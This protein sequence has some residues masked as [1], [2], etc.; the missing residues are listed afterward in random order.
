[1]N[2]SSLYNLQDEILGALSDFARKEEFPFVLTGGTALVRFLLKRTYRV[3]YDLDFFYQGLSL[4]EWSKRELEVF[5]LGRFPL[6]DFRSLSSSTLNMWRAVI[7]NGSLM[8]A[9]DFVE[10]PFSG[11]FETVPLEDF[12][13][14]KMETAQEGVY[15][16][17]VFAITSYTREEKVIERIKDVVDLIELDKLIFLQDFILQTYSRIMKQNFGPLNRRKFLT[18]FSGLSKIIKGA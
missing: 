6:V 13:P 16:R 10:D 14:L 2:F 1:L 5:L 17:K 18:K 3:S 7:G 15:F 4:E 11:I 12:Q 9:V 8:V